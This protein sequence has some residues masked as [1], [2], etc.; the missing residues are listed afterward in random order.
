MKDQNFSTSILVDQTPEEVF[1]AINN[2]RGWWSEN[3]EG[4]TD[5]PGIFYY[6]YQDIHRCT[7]KIT[8]FMPG[9]KVVWHVLQN[10]FSFVEE[11][12][13]WTGIDVVFDIARKGDQTEIRFTH[14][15]L[16]PENECHDV[17]TDAW[18]TYI[19]HSLFDLITK[20]KGDPTLK[21]QKDRSVQQTSL[22]NHPN[23]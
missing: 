22:E 11:Q 18:D 13:E 3:I 15:G 9:K 5:R 17:C 6:Y 21:G 14:V 7:F 10:Y 23:A 1:R 19:N 8:E 20:G 12:T 4:D 16:V 2:V